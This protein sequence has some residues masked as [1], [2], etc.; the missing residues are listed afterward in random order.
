MYD[1]DNIITA[2]CPSLDA[3]IPSS[4]F[5]H[6]MNWLVFNDRAIVQNV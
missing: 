2:D 4:G 6:S 5:A 3:V 1:I